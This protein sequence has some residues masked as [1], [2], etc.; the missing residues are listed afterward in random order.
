MRNLRG[1]TEDPMQPSHNFGRCFPW[2]GCKLI[3]SK[4][5]SKLLHNATLWSSVDSLTG[6][7]VRLIAER[8]S[9]IVHAK[10]AFR[11]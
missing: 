5:L 4:I 1:L 8:A 2:L 11:E 7:E 10:I 6:R 9:I 3:G